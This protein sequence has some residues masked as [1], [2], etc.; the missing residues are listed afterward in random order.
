MDRNIYIT[1]AVIGIG[2]I[3][4]LGYQIWAKNTPPQ[5]VVIVK[6]EGKS[7]EI[8][9]TV[10]E[11]TKGDYIDMIDSTPNAQSRTW[12]LGDV[13]ISTDSSISKRFDSTGNFLLS[14]LVNNE[15]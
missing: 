11:V 1:L 15:W 4:W 5:V 13:T 7:D 14:L 12:V 2:A 8:N 6:V 3:T 10:V 9:P